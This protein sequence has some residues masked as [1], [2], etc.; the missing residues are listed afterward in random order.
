MCLTQ[1]GVTAGPPIHHG[2][3]LLGLVRDGEKSL[4]LAP[5]TNFLELNPGQA[6]MG[7]GTHIPGNPAQT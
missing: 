3:A 4:M 5:G 6:R 2:I 7:G 1:V